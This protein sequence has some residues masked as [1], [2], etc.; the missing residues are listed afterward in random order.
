LFLACYKGEVEQVKRILGSNDMR[1]DLK[2]G[3]SDL[4]AFTI[5]CFFGHTE[6]VQML[7]QDPRIDISDSESNG[8]NAAIIDRHLDIVKILLEEERL[9]ENICSFMNHSEFICTPWFCALE[10]GKQ[11]IIDL[12]LRV[13]GFS[14]I[15]PLFDITEMHVC[16][17]QRNT[18]TFRELFQSSMDPNATDAHN[19]TPLAYAASLGNLEIFQILI[20]SPL[21]SPDIFDKHGNSALHHAARG[22][23]VEIVEI[24]LKDPRFDNNL[25]NKHLKTP[26][27]VACVKG[28]E[29]VLM[30][31]LT[32][33]S[34]RPH[35]GHGP[36]M[37]E[38]CKEELP[39]ILAYCLSEP[40]F[41]TRSFSDTLLKV[42]A[43]SE[44]IENFRIL[45][46]SDKTDPTELDR[47]N[48]SALYYA[49]V[50]GH[51]EM[52]RM[53]LEDGRADLFE[54]GKIVQCIITN[55]R[56]EILKF[57]LENSESFAQDY[58]SL[59]NFELFTETAC[60]NIENVKKLFLAGVDVNQQDNNGV[61]AIHVACVFESVEMLEILL[62]QPL[63]DVNLP[64]H[65][66]STA[67]HLA[68]KNEKSVSVI[69]LLSHDNIHPNILNNDEETAFFLA[70]K[71]EN[72]TIIELFL[73]CP[74]VN[75]SATRAREKC[76]ISFL[77]EDYAD[78]PEILVIMKDSRFAH[79]DY[80]PVLKIACHLKYFKIVEFIMQ[81]GLVQPSVR[82]FNKCVGD[83]ATRKKYNLSTENV[84]LICSMFSTYSGIHPSNYVDDQ[85]LVDSIV[86][87]ISSNR[88]KSAR[89]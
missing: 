26:L 19:M 51:I 9:T 8:L 69:R 48:N 66:G 81:E 80:E 57:L 89:K 65:E 67:L 75:Q 72:R 43:Q 35:S 2:H 16:V 11:E 73:H 58:N 37:F 71:T 49:V 21:V 88:S 32:E 29:K 1:V 42:A 23:H 30:K 28:N 20:S 64:T 60:G 83:K 76:L 40:K 55:G 79:I 5:S 52:V 59:G 56:S 87:E 62:S 18:E 84:I 13:G 31:L 41:E 45:L 61:A 10:S 53:L 46:G 24:L 15:F 17:L 7:L 4:S 82:L 3:H 44:N 22:G 47:I 34:V 27:G 25:T 77:M 33:S 14:N 6:I 54:N 39:E 38:I 85:S 70:A 86:S 50:G 12:L 36:I 78:E 68:A 74:K 63:V